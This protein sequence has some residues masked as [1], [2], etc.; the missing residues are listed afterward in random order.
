M[1]S[2]LSYLIRNPHTRP[3]KLLMTGMQY[4]LQKQVGV[5]L[6]VAGECKNPR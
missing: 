3:M 2:M 6:N 1:E 5:V 4:L